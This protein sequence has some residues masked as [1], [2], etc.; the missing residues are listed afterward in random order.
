MF[1]VD[2]KDSWKM[3]IDVEFKHVQNHWVVAR[4]TQL[5]ILPRSI[6][7]VPGT[8]GNFLLKSKLPPRSDSGLEAVEPKP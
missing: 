7:W 3:T 6:K 1:K 8:S 4:S 5:F 2:D